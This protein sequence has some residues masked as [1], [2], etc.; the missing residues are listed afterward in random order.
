MKIQIKDWV[1]YDN[2]P[3]TD[4]TLAADEFDVLIFTSPLNVDA[5]VQQFSIREHQKI[6]AIGDTTAQRLQH[7][8]Y[9][10]C[11]AHSP[12]EMALAAWVY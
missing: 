7:Y 4:T 12:D 9:T 3:A 10:A 5:F 8:G 1:I 6:I 2:T 11:V